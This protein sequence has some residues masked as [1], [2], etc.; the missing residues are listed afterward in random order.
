MQSTMM[1]F[2]RLRTFV[3]A[4]RVQNFSE[5]SAQLGYVQSAVTAQIKALEDELQVSLFDRNGRGVQLTKAGERLLD[6]AER[7]FMLRDEAKEAISS[8]EHIVGDMTIAGYETI[9]TY[10][11]PHT[12]DRFVRAYPSVRLNIRPLQVRQLK[13]QV[14]NANI[15]VAFVLEEPFQIPGLESRHIRDEKILI[16]AHPEHPL[17]QQKHVTANDLQGE[18]I[19]L[20]EQGC[21][22]RNLFE[23]TL[24]RAGAYNGPRL[25]FSSIESIKACVKVGTGIAALSEV[26]VSEDIAN[27]KLVALDWQ[28]DA[29]SVGLYMVWNKNRWLSPAVKAFIDNV[30]TF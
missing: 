5:A 19:L 27:G 28:D 4:A 9:L 24:I 7:L 23:R 15:D 30:K 13:N 1:D 21:N 22:Y 16:V 11:L 6:Y 17:S 18:Q 14:L 29:L 26:S 10:R 20:T 2:K 3:T 12:L 25:E 8:T